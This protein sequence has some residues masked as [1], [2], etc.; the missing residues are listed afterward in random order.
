MGRERRW[1]DWHSVVCRWK[2]FLVKIREEGSLSGSFLSW[3]QRSHMI[4]TSDIGGVVCL[5]VGHAT[6]LERLVLMHILWKRCPHIRALSSPSSKPRRQTEHLSGVVSVSMGASSGACEEYGRMTSLCP[7]L[8]ILTHK[9]SCLIKYE[10][11]EISPLSF[12]ALAMA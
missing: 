11:R 12:L 2:H 7:G 8:D 4:I 5:H 9:T 10:K 6:V 1:L 3:V